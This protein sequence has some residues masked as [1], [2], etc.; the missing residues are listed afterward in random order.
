MNRRYLIIGLVLFVGIAAGMLLGFLLG[1]SGKVRIPGEE[2]TFTAYLTGYSYFDNTPPGSSAVA[3]PRSKGYATVHDRAD[4]TGTYNNPVTLAVGHSLSDQGD[5]PDF[6]P[7]TMFYIPDFKKYFV[8]EDICGD[9][10]SPQDGPCHAGYQEYAW[11]DVWV[12]GQA[13]E[14]ADAADACENRI[15]GTHR[16]ILSPS[17]RYAV[18]PGSLLQSK[19]C[20]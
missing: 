13:G 8:V 6:D 11:L 15:T 10:G 1:R 14:S 19:A 5:I 3:F 16:V 18:E 4:G 9:G 17:P 2:T 12:G 7:G 20:K